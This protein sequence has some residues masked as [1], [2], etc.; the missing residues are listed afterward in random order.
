[1]LSSTTI[2]QVKEIPVADVIQ[3]YIELKKQG[4]NL[5]CKSPFTEEKSASFTVSPAKNIFKCFSSGKGG[6]AISF[7]M[8]FRKLSYFETI[9]E[10][11]DKFNIVVEHD[12]SEKANKEFLRREKVQKINNIN[13]EANDFFVSNYQNVEPKFIRATAEISNQFSLGFAPNEWQALHNHLLKKGFSKKEMEEAGL[14]KKGEKTHYDFFRGR[15]MFPITDYNGNIIG[16]S[17]RLAVDVKEGEKAPSKVTNSLETEAYSKSNSLLGIFIAKNNILKFD[18]AIVVEGNYDV[19]SLHQVGLTNTIGCLGT[20]FTEEQCKLI[21]RFTSN[22]VFAIDNDKAGLDKIEKNTKLALSLGMNVELFI[23]SIEGQD[24]DDFVKVAISEGLQNKEIIEKFT[25]LKIDA[26]DY[27]ADKLFSD[28]STTVK[29]AQAEQDLVKLLCCISNGLLRNKYV[30]KYVSK[31][32]VDKAT[33]EKSISLSFVDSKAEQEENSKFKM[34][35]FLNEDEMV[36]FK[37]FG[38][39]PDRS[40]DKIGYYFQENSRP[41]RV[42]NWLMRPLF[43]VLNET[44]SKRFIE[45]ET[46]KGKIVIEIPNKA[47]N[48][49]QGFEDVISN[50]GGYFFH[51]SKKQYQRLKSKFLLQ[52]P[53][54]VEIRTLGWHYNGF[55]SFSNGIVVDGQFKDIDKLGLV[56]FGSDTYFLPAFSSIY[57]DAQAEDDFYENDRKFIYKSIGTGFAKWAKKFYNV[58][59]D[60]DNGMVALMFAVSTLFSD[61]IYAQNNDF[62][63]AFGVGQPRTGKTT[64]ARSV[65]RLFKSDSLPFNLNQGTVI[66]FQRRLARV[67]NVVEHLDEYQ[68]DIDEK[69]FQSLKGI[70]DRT[71]HEKGIM[72][73]DN[74]TE[75]V[76]INATGFI[77][78]QQFPNRDGNSLTTRILL[79]DFT[80][81]HEDFSNEEIKEFNDLTKLEDDGLSDVIVEI[82]K[83]RSLIEDKFISTQYQLGSKLKDELKDFNADGRVMKNYGVL[84]TCMKI[85]ENSLSFPFTYDYMYE[86]CKELILSQSQRIQESDQLAEFFKQIEY[87]SSMHMIRVNKDYKLVKGVY[88]IKVGRKEK[89]TVVQFAKPKNIIYLKFAKIFPLYKETIRK[90]GSNGLDEQTILSYMKTH[91][92]F[93]GA[94]A[95]VNFDGQKTSGYAFDQDILQISLEDLEKESEHEEKEQAGFK[96]YPMLEPETVQ[97]DLPF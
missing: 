84:L 62:P 41:E 47:I 92:A 65:S 58:Y 7:V 69:R 66:G 45:L 83:Y 56:H 40:K 71:G 5:V 64:C 80:K 88:E 87:L 19:T 48:N 22:I 13:Q 31:Y 35:S 73:R 52:F 28:T 23:P 11:A 49:P 93:L 18:S 43:Q 3:K 68:N 16:F 24:P 70:F 26:I 33:V 94:V 97:E 36:D 25:S 85:L 63:L 20:A 34:P 37:E 61:Y 15:V 21:K 67:R 57:K 75:S 50:K 9:I 1:M 42:S 54:C 38:F 29:E 95:S 81:K 59:R 6:N 96:T 89:A 17:G 2:N 32:K 12:N 10:I 79:M 14:I 27:L 53:L 90:Q 46:A 4:A 76:K 72:S 86:K 51:G 30:K 82:I 44:D 60:N 77:T 91:K 39:Y 74:R 55:F 78:G 8:E